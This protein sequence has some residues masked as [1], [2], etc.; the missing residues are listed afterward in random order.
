LNPPPSRRIF[1]PALPYIDR[2]L[3]AHNLESLERLL[4]LLAA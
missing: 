4:P 2:L 1:D 3:P